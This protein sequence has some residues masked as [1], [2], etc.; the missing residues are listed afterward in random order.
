MTIMNQCTRKGKIHRIVIKKGA[1]CNFDLIAVFTGEKIICEGQVTLRPRDGHESR[2]DQ[3][4]DCFFAQHRSLLFYAESPATA[5]SL[6]GHSA[7]CDLYRFNTSWLVPRLVIHAP[8]IQRE[9]GIS[10]GLKK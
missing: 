9:A 8:S 4:E 2:K 5:Q 6:L 10:A 3:N 7:D 1:I